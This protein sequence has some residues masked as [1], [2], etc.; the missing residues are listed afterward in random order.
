MAI[1]GLL[2]VSSGDSPNIGISYTTVIGT[3]GSADDYKLDI[4][5]L[6]ERTRGRRPVVVGIH[7]GGWCLGDKSLKNYAK[8]KPNYFL[9]RRC[10]YVSINYRLSPS[11]P[12]AAV[13]AGVAGTNTW[14]DSRVKFPSHYQDTATALRWVYDNIASYGGDKNKIILTGHSAG[15]QIASVLATNHEFINAVG[16]PTTS[17]KAVLMMDTEG[18]NV[19][20][21]I[22][23]PTEGD[24]NSDGSGDSLLSRLFYENAFGIYPGI[25][26]G[27]AYRFKDFPIATYGTTAA[28][29]AAAESIYNRSSPDQNITLSAS[30][31]Y[32]P[33]FLIIGRGS[34]DRQ[35][36][37]SDFYNSL[38]SAGIAATYINYPGDTTYTHEEVNE[39]LGSSNDPPAGKTLPSGVNNITNQ[40]TSFINN[41]NLQP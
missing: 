14:N 3:G 29:I 1:T 19:K 10:I 12:V 11:L 24:T 5:H 17:I 25:H 8:F 6:G 9:K 33:N 13:W 30:K 27:T 21:Q 39:C 7:G 23:Y 26:T 20:K 4:Y 40:V 35:T 36:R 32:I 18:G 2:G 34:P 38:I 15:A 41:L 16:V 28:A 31:P 37:Q 22:V